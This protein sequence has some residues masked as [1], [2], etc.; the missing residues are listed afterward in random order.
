MHP[1]KELIERLRGYR[2]RTEWGDDVE[3]AICNE[4]ADRLEALSG[5]EAVAW[6][7]DGGRAGVVFYD[8][9]TEA[10]RGQKLFGGSLQPLAAPRPVPGRE[11]IEAALDAKLA[12]VG[13]AYLS[14]QLGHATITT[15]LTKYAR[16][17][18]GADKGSEAAKLDAILSRK[19]PR[20]TGTN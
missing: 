16:W 15:T 4:A 7:L 9:W 12:D 3:H 2:S 20:K 1:D 6:R 11:T 5:G 8:D 18:E 10:E 19:S 17:I 13:G 14:K